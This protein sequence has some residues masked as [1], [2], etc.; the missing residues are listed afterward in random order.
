[1]TVSKLPEDYGSLLVEVKERIRAA[2]YRAL[3]AVNKELV[4][5]YRDIGRMIMEWRHPGKVNCPTTGWRSARG[6]SRYRRLFCLQSL[7]YE[8]VFRSICRF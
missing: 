4:G 3:R 2:R 5:L 6:V 7:A 8:V 1:M